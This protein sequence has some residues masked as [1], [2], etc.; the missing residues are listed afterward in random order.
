MALFVGDNAQVVVHA[1][2]AR[3]H[4]QARTK[5]GHGALV[6]AGGGFDNRQVVERVGAG[7]FDVEQATTATVLLESWCIG[8]V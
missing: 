1:R 2:V 6:I 5:T 7:G 8:P 4:A 3:L